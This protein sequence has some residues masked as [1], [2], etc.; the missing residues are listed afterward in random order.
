MLKLSIAIADE[1][2]LQSAFVVFRGFEKHIPIA[3]E[4]GYNGVELALKKASDIKI[5]NLDRLLKS[6][7]LN[8]SCIS[9]GQVFAE[10]GYMF[11]DS[12]KNRRNILRDIYK[13]F[14]DLAS[15]YGKLVN[16]GRVRGIIGDKNKK[17]CENRF[18][19]LAR[20]LCEYAQPKD[21]TLILE[22]VN[23]YEI[24]FINNLEEGVELLGKIN[25]S[26]MKLMPDIFHMN[27]ED[28][29][30]GGELAK[31]IDHISYIHFADS[32]RLAPGWGHIDFKE[33]F[34]KLKLS[35]Y[36]GW[37]SVE[38]LPKPDPSSAAKQAIDYLKPFI[39][40]YNL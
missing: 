17:N 22:P 6:S 24:N 39:S 1:D 37:L 2:A 40:R 28:P 19:D 4:L 33:V 36:S 14:I 27:I 16:I 3:A 26:N 7:G 8:V 30:I 10:S 21:V 18:I 13:D 29:T 32:N 20:E 34:E 12:D 11:T 5:N 25:M 15:N 9:T 38:I 23:R 31:H 35:N